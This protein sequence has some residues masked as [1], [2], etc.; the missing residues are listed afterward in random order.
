LDLSAQKVT[1]WQVDAHEVG[2][3]SLLPV[4]ESVVASGDDDGC[5]KLW[6]SRQKPAAA[7]FSSH[8]D[9]ISGF[10]YQVLPQ[11]VCPEIVFLR[12]R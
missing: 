2:I 12:I 1:K 9:Y 5:V 6:D 11:P 8:T 3:N 4:S 7:E 10:A